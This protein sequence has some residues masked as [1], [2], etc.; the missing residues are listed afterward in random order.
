M[1]AL[2]E[3]LFLAKEAGLVDIITFNKM[4]KKDEKTLES[5]LFNVEATE[6]DNK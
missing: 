5:F 6:F 4:I 2:Y 3:K 1:L